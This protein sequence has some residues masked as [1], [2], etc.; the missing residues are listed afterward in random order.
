MTTISKPSSLL[1]SRPLI[2]AEL[3]RAVADNKSPLHRMLRYHLG[4]IDQMGMPERHASPD[5]VLGTLTLLSAEAVGASAAQAVPGAAA[6]ELTKAYFQIHEELR[7]GTPEVAGRPALWWHAGAS[8]GINAGDGMYALARLELMRLEELDI[9]ADRITRALATLDRAS[10][11]VTETLYR[12]IT[13][14]G[15][16]EDTPEAHIEAIRGKAA[17][18]GAACAMGAI[19]GN[20]SPRVV[21]ALR[22]F[23]E[24]TGTAAIVREELRAIRGVHG[25]SR[26]Q[27]VEMLDKRRSLPVLA[28]LKMATGN[29][30]AA[31]T[32][33]AVR[34]G[35]LSD[36]RLEKL[37]V[38]MESTGAVRYCEETIQQELQ[39]GL[40]AMK[41][42]AL[43]AD[44]ADRL[45][46][47]A[48]FAAGTH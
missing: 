2:E 48:R 20:G 11:R 21:D 16:L 47:L 22:S 33:T 8:Q 18:H 27:L 41:A 24:R 10:L 9:S 28:L 36:E 38:L 45:A 5:R 43:P 44:A 14:E 17:I 39:E 3:K 25:S 6:M 32:A 31:L 23:G 19:I 34:D 30:R 1:E 29:D 42:A 13:A 35:P 40:E 4:W 37:A 26:S 15:T 12:A 46:E 7:A